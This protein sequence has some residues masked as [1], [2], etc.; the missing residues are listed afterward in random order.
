MQKFFLD[1]VNCFVKLGPRLFDIDSGIFQNGHSKPTQHMTII[2]NVFVVMTL[3]NEV[4]CRKIHGERNVFN[5]FFSNPLFYS[6]L[7]S[8]AFAQ[9]FIIQFAGPLFRTVPLTID[10]WMWCIMFGIGELIWAQIILFLPSQRMPKRFTFNG[11]PAKS[12][13]LKSEQDRE[14]DE[15]D[16]DEDSEMNDTVDDLEDM[17]GKTLWLRGVARVRT[18]IRVVNAFQTSI[19]RVPTPNMVRR[20]SMIRA[21]SAQEVNTA[22][23][24]VATKVKEA[25][26]MRSSGS[27][28]VLPTISQ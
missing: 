18:Q 16:E 14:L 3:F 15:Y 8:S 9:V 22:A 2:F 25:R 4:N 13:S 24:C 12:P 6:I 21:A 19:R 28:D 10:Q 26:A 17:D 11:L 20:A 27:I 7:I 1:F 23:V 5:G